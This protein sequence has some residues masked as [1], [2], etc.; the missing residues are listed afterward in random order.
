MNPVLAHPAVA[1]LRSS[2]PIRE[3]L[4]ALFDTTEFKLVTQAI[5]ATTRPTSIPAPV[6]GLHPDTVTAHETHRKMGVCQGM[7]AILAIATDP[8]SHN[9]EFTL[10]GTE[11]DH[12][13]PPELRN[14]PKP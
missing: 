12:A 3:A 4:K 11:F 8:G 1:K 2:A 7:D 9:S 5:Y 14:K 13:L 10:E 6:A